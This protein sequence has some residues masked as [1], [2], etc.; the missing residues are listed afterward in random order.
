MF[1]AD[2]ATREELCAVH[3][4][5]NDFADPRHDRPLSFVFTLSDADRYGDVRLVQAV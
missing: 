1:Y 5:S 4:T 3:V 2:H